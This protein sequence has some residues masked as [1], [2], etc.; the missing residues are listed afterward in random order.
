MVKKILILSAVC[1]IVLIMV[2]LLDRQTRSLSTLA[3]RTNKVKHYK[4]SI[5]MDYEVAI[6]IL[7]DAKAKDVT[8]T[9]SNL[10]I[11][12]SENAESFNRYMMLKDKTCIYLY[13]ETKGGDSA[14]VLVEIAIGRD[15]NEPILT[16]KKST[17][18]SFELR[19]TNSG[20]FVVRVVAVE[21]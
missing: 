12:E 20:F 14:P 16:E 9:I 11:N 17:I 3:E 13:G 1:V 10:T 21:K 2:K 19:E 18:Q 6:K 7:F 4:V 5:G 8:S 15:G